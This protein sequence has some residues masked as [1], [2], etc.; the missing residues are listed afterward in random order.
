MWDTREPFLPAAAMAVAVVMPVVF[1]AKA[2]KKCNK[3]TKIICLLEIILYIF[4][5]CKI[6]CN[7]HIAKCSVAR[8]QVVAWLEPEPLWSIDT[9]I[10][11]IARKLLSLQERLT[12][13]IKA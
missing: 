1:F 11:G 2:T 6:Y 12:D 10:L 3:N 7:S 9:C 5:S 13:Y 4:I 8:A